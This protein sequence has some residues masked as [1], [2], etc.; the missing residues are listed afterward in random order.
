VH[1]RRMGSKCPILHEKYDTNGS[2][3]ALTIPFFAAMNDADP[4]PCCILL[5]AGGVWCHRDSACWA[6]S[7]NDSGW[8]VVVGAEAAAAEVVDSH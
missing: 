2:I 8:A 4:S 7:G 6:G 3:R 1:G 5:T